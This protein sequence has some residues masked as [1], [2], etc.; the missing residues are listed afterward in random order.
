MQ[1]SLSEPTVINQFDLN[2]TNFDIFHSTC[3][4]NGTD[5][6][7]SRNVDQLN[8]EY[9]KI[10]IGDAIIGNGEDPRAFDFLGI[11]ACYSVLYRNHFGFFPQLYFLDENGWNCKQ[12]I[13]GEPLAPGKNW[14]P[15]VF[16]TEIYFVHEISPFRVIKLTG[17]TV[18][19]VFKQE[20]ETDIQQND[21]YPVLR[22]GCN[23]LH[24]GNGL[25]LGFGHDNRLTK[26]GDINTIK[27]RP[28]CWCLD[29]NNS[30]VIIVDIKFCWDDRFN[31]IDPTAFIVRDNKY[32]LMTCETSLI[33][34]NSNQCGRSCLYPVT[35]EFGLINSVKAIFR[36]FGIF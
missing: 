20:I 19:T 4:I 34:S 10:R 13:M 26:Q 32:F 11:P 29:M 36:Q 23:G 16:G 14:S 3:S 22:G 8:W 27:H 5:Y 17:D 33:W 7:F 30:G 1:I 25:V 31:I 12:I 2:P 35:I 6:I 15:F 18:N 24:I 9:T 21:N 28:F